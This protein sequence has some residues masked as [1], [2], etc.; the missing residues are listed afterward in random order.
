M[1]R[2]L[3]AIC[4][5]GRY[6][7]LGRLAVGGMAEIYLAREPETVEG[8]GH[9]HLVIKR[10]LQ[11]VADD[12]TFKTMFF[13]EARLAMRLNHPSIVHIYEF[14][15]EEGSYFLAMEWVD[16]VALGKII[17][18]SRQ[19]GGM[20]AP[21]AVKIIAQVAEALHYA[22]H[23]RDDDGAELGIIHRDVSPQNIMVSYDGAVKLLDFGIA[24]ATIQHTKTGD[25]Q[26]KGKF[27]YMSPQQCMGEDIDA[28]AD[29]FS[30]GVCLYEALTG[31]PLYH[32]KTQYET[33]RAVIEEKVPSIR[34][35]RPDLPE[36]LDAIVQR[37][38][39]KNSAERFDTAGS[40]Q[41]AL[42]GWLAEQREVVP[43]PRIT[44]LLEDTF[45]E[46]IRRGPMVD[47]MPFGQ[48]FQRVE[49]GKLTPPPESSGSSGKLLASRAASRPPSSNSGGL[50]ALAASSEPYAIDV[51]LADADETGKEL[52]NR[53]AWLVG[54]SLLIVLLVFG[55]LAAWWVM[56]G[57][58]ET[59]VANAPTQPVPVETPEVVQPTPLGPTESQRGGILVRSEPPGASVQLGTRDVP[60]TTPTA[61]YDL[62][63]GSY[64][65]T[66]TLDGY[67]VH[68]QNVS[69]SP[70]GEIEVDAELQPLV[71]AVE[72]QPED[73]T[74]M[75]ER[76]SDMVRMRVQM[77]ERMVALM[78]EVVAE[79]G[80]VSVNTR[81][82]SKVYVGSRLL[83]T[84]PIGRAELPAG[85]VRFRIVD[86][87]GQEHSRSGT[88]RAGQ[89][90][91]VFFDLTGVQ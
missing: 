78:E 1:V 75:R 85:P 43:A 5:F 67:Q 24:K 15:E 14:G 47:S 2:N 54:A 80:T 90:T 26:V 39:A 52:T 29:V 48:S 32:R 65:L 25:G 37:A 28:R 72:P 64:S 62:E 89:N 31:L 77:R 19:T 22:H 49:D 51:E 88:V 35:H 84:T 70:G 30:L 41:I 27:A 7:L 66:L 50:P 74:Q 18:K 61:L 16:G 36:E 91:P 79:T 86:R 10:V 38:L 81:P 11:H 44:K 83:G 6:E 33:M 59:D 45:G 12:P 46:D 40:L 56:S 34:T 76:R 13:D 9:R 57:K 87:D 55:G 69:I 58:G 8:A 53:A 42:E 3:P 82:W 4:P 68:R 60:G 71:A 63:P 21:V 17:R 20:P 23:L 73:T